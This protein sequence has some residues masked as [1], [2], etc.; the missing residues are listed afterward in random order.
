VV[1]NVSITVTNIRTN[2]SSTTKTNGVG[3]YTVPALHS[4]EYSVTA[5]TTGFKKSV[6][7]GLILQVNDVAVVDLF[8]KWAT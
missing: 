5:E 6:R 3:L 8:L 2:I 1:P 7:S 4:G